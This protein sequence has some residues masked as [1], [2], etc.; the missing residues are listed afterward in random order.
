MT[1]AT[2]LGFSHLTAFTTNNVFSSS[3][4]SFLLVVLFLSS[5]YPLVGLWIHYLQI[6]PQ[7][8]EAA[9]PHSERHDV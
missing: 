8:L 5:F 2:T 6:N 1:R 7:R 9:D 4:S 3:S